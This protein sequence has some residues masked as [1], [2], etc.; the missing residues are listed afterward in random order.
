MMELPLIELGKAGRGGNFDG[1]NQKL[2]VRLC[3]FL[4]RYLFK[5]LSHSVSLV[6]FHGDKCAFINKSQGNTKLKVWKL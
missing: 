5:T 1:K 4:L 6:L 3:S 2:S